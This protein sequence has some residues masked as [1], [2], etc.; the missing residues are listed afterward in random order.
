MDL[1]TTWFVVAGALL[2]VYAV[3]EVDIGV[4]I[5]SLFARRPERA[6]YLG[7]VGPAWYRREVWLVL[8]G[9]TLLAAFPGIEEPL[10]MG[11]LPILALLAAAFVVRAVALP[12][13]ASRASA[14]GRGACEVAFGAA[15]LA[16]AVLLGVLA[17][18]VL[19]GV[20][21][22]P[23][24]RWQGP[25]LGLLD[26]YPLLLGLAACSA[27]V[28]HGAVYLRTRTSGEASDR[29]GGIA[30]GA[31]VGF[32][33]LCTAAT[34]ATMK[35]S[36][37]L[38]ANSSST[39]FRIATLALLGVFG[40]TP[41]AATAGRHRMA[42]VASSATITALVAVVAFSLY[43][44]LLPSRTSLGHSLTIFNAAAAPRTLAAMIVFGVVAVPLLF[45]YTHLGLR[46]S[47]RRSLLRA[48]GDVPGHEE[49]T[50][51]SS[52]AGR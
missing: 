23:P 28:V 16:I 22:G 3:L 40:A 49:A 11:F 44:G 31:F 26:P 45:T 50:P 43:P 15:S 32:L 18:D 10:L 1:E 9:A 39:S 4:G 29:V 14:R 30:L 47:T 42:L 7:A 34:T 37:F 51:P 48:G 6:L 38:F 46:S 25:P 24:P 2:A 5:L 19:R 8:A 41:V 20:P 12:L 33:G 17:G 13:R 21:I 52:V 35:V 36:P 27:F